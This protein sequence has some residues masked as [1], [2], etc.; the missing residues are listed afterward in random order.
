MKQWLNRNIIG[1]SLAS[2]FSDFCHEMTIAIL[3]TYIQGI[4]G[5]LYAPFTLGLI[6]GIADVAST[7]MKLI[8]GFV[9]DKVSCYKPF[10]VVGYGLTGIVAFIGTTKNVVMILF[11]SI[12]AWMSQGIREPIRDTWISKIVSPQFYGRVFGFH[13]AC[14]TL[15]ALCGPLCAFILLKYNV[16]IAAVFMFALIPGLLAVVPILFLTHEEKAERVTGSVEKSVI[17]FRDQLTQ[18]PRDFNYFLMVMLVFGLANFNKTLFIY[19]A[20]SLL[21]QHDMS[22]HMATGW[23]LLFYVLYNSVRA[24]GEFGMG[25]ASDY[26]SR[27]NLLAIFGFGL[28]SVTTLCFLIPATTITMLFLFFACAGF[29]AGTVKSL[30]KSYAAT[31]LP[32]HVRGTGLGLLQA[33]NGLG[34]LCSS[35]MVGGLWSFIS[36]VAG[37]VYAALLSFTAM[38]ML[39]IRK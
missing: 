7:M 28:F 23:A 9:A 19:R 12:I 17:T 29:S 20:Q 39:L 37:F 26:M 5:A 36:P 16:S 24:C 34:N 22:L 33:V 18:L 8:S 30:E 38:G 13:R 21:A 4:T 15:G 1:F 11:Y 2:F 27:K 31:L 35:L 14:D 6:Q 10:L 32:E 25:V 3:P